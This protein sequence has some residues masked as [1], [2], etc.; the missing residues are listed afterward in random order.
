MLN[1]ILL[2]T[3]YNFHSPLLKFDSMYYIAYVSID[4]SCLLNKLCESVRTGPAPGKVVQYLMLG[5][6]V[7]FSSQS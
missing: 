6:R 2:N 7:S 3:I 1:Y 5:F 4:N